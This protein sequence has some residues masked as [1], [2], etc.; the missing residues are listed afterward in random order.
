MAFLKPKSRPILGLDISTS[1]VKLIELSRGKDGYRVEAF[2]AEVMPTN[3]VNDKVITDIEAAGE[4]IRNAAKKAGTRVKHAA[5]AVG[6]ASV[7]TKVVPMPAALSDKELG[8]Q[9]EL[10]ADQYIPFPLEEVS[11]DYEIVGPTASD[12]EMVDVLLAATRRENVEQRQE[13]LVGGGLVAKV[14]DIEAYALENA[15]K[16]LTH[17]LAD[18]GFGKT[19]AVVD[20]GSTTTTFSVLHDRKIV[21]TRDQ[22][23][24]GKQLTEEIMRHYGLSYEE[25]G[26]AKK[27]GGLPGNYKTD[28]LDLFVEDMAQQVNRSLQFFLSS[29]SEYNQ[30]D[31]IVICGGCAQ[32]PQA[33]EHITERLGVRTVVADPFGQM[34]ISSKAKA[35]HVEHEAP[36]LMIACGLAMR[37]FD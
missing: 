4:A 36:S 30:L 1:S 29:T 15:C 32:I 13:A 20:F 28:I 9:I 31:Q 37:S 35:Q 17:Q 7:I 34:S 23:F 2:A 22:G 10:Q 33:A 11:Y 3:A 18:E 5:V 12:P 19:I 26:K 25:A 8:E 27:E 21:Y 16:L 6:G 14:V 24:G